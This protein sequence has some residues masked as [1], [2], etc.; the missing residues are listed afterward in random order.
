MCTRIPIFIPETYILREI[1]LPFRTP[2]LVSSPIL[3]L[4]SGTS[5]PNTSKFPTTKA[6]YEGEGG[7]R[8]VVR[9]PESETTSADSDIRQ[10][11]SSC[12][13]ELKFRPPQK[14]KK[15]SVSDDSLNQIVCS[16]AC[17]CVAN[18]TSPLTT[19]SMVFQNWENNIPI[20]LSLIVI[21]ALSLFML[22]KYF[23]GR[24]L[25]RLC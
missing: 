9:K 8:T 24:W 14:S 16:K 4:S 25:L 21:F 7:W 1:I 22:V 3:P 13:S 11:P 23:C 6:T 15:R 17:Q 2:I 19:V 20:I 18:P 10:Q 12:S 5:R